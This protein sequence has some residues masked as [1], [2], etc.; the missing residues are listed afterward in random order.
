MIVLFLLLLI[1]VIQI[2]YCDNQCYLLKQPLL[3]YKN[4]LTC[5]SHNT[6]DSFLYHE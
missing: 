1:F 4:Q 6:I 3:I 2:N 5:I